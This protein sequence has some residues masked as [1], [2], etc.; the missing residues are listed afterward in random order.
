MHHGW[1]IDSTDGLKVVVNFWSGCNGHLTHN[2][3][4]LCGVAKCNVIVLVVVRS[5]SCSVVDVVEV[6]ML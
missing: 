5:C 1:Q 2:C 6:V 4:M 3:R